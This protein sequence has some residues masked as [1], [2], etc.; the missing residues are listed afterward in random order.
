M[1][2]R[3]IGQEIA[4]AM[5]TEPCIMN[6]LECRTLTA[7]CMNNP[8]VYSMA[9]TIK[10]SISLCMLVQYQSCTWRVLVGYGTVLCRSV[11]DWSAGERHLARS[12]Y[13]LKASVTYLNKITHLKATP[14]LHCPLHWQLTSVAQN[15]NQSC[16]CSWGGCHVN[17]DR[18]QLYTTIPLDRT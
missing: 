15:G 2:Y 17:T 1:L 4:M 13:K 10:P 3:C 5:S 11:H 14:C 16:T 7:V 6:A 12:L 9:V 18:K 8:R